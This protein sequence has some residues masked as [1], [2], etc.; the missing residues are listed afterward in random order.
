MPFLINLSAD[1]IHDIDQAVEY[2]NKV[3]FG[4]GFEFANTLDVFFGN[5]SRLPTASAIR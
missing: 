5:I 1:A 2:Y 4:L 3:S